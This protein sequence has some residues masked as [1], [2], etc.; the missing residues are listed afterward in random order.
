MTTPA[1]DDA[2]NLC[3][4]P[5]LPHEPILHAVAQFTGGTRRFV[6]PLEP[7]DRGGGAVP[8]VLRDPEESGEV[9]YVNRYDRMLAVRTD[10]TTV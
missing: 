6:V 10:G 3:M 5:L 7:G 8:L 9:V 2:G 1:F 4:T